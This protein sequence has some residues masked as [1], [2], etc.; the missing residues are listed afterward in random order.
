MQPLG[1]SIAYTNYFVSEN[2]QSRIMSLNY[3]NIAELPELN[4]IGWYY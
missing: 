3:S 1:I 2:K 4:V